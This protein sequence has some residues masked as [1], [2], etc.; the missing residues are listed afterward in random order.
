MSLE[1]I[2]AKQNRSLLVDLR[3]QE[4]TF[5]DKPE[6]RVCPTLG[7]AFVQLELGFLS[8]KTS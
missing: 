2:L 4:E 6:A 8:L 3:M 5:F 1:V 7:H